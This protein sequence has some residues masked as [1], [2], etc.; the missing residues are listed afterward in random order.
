LIAIA[1]VATGCGATTKTI[2][3]PPAVDISGRWVGTWTGYD[4]LDISRIEE[5]TADFLQQGARGTGRLVLH[6]TAG[7]AGVP[8]N[9]RNA[10]LT[11]VRVEFQVSGS[12]V[13]MRHEL[14]GH[15]FI[16]DL[17]VEKDRMV[18]YLRDAKPA[19]RV[20]LTRVG[21]GGSGAAAPV[22]ASPPAPAPA[23]VAPEPPKTPEP[24]AAAP[25]P[26]PAA[27]PAEP[28]RS[29]PKEF[30]EIDAVKPIFFDFDRYDIR[31]DDAKILDANAEWLQT[32][33]EILLLIEGHCDERGAA[34]YNLAL[35]ERRA[36]ATRHYLISRGIA[37]ERISTV[38]V[39]EDRVVCTEQTD[40]CW[41]KNRRAITLVKPR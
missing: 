4:F 16:A 11:G 38:G 12:E 14:G 15:F 6:S 33:G 17:K 8:E 30:A 18:G 37:A 40:A 29:A 10:G 20:V 9:L 3:A 34:E 21:G 31:P 1:L 35:G 7:A 39:G 23:P 24:I 25:A 32:N 28:A 5:A 13:V 22:V 2:N 26:P 27:P 19:V 41:S 36:Q